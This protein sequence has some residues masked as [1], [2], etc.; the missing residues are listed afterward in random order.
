MSETLETKITAK[1]MEK[2]LAIRYCNPEWVFLPQVRSSTGAADRIAD[3]V[4]FNM[5]QSTGYSIVGFEI[6]VSRADWLSELKQMSKS[7]EIM[8]YCDKWYLVVPDAAIVKDGELPKN[9]GLL[10]LKDGKLVQK[11][12][13]VPHNPTLMPLCFIASL[14]RRSGDEVARIRSQYVKREDIAAEIEKAR[15]WGYESARGYN[16]KQTENALK[17]LR[18]LVSEFEKASGVPFESWRGKQYTKSL[19][20]YVNV[21]MKLN[22]DTLKYDLS[23][24]EDVVKSLERAATD[25]RKI[26][27]ELGKEGVV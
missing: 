20:L 8:K 4:A 7:N 22:E 23:R 21:A 3:G 17:E 25:M 11:V 10:V 24:I 2:H 14:L 27:N 12:R 19:G 9:W 18:E 15:Q 26:K 13:P 6:K 1:D 16:G 5:Y